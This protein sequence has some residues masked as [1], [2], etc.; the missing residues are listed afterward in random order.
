ML[1]LKTIEPMIR[2][3]LAED[4]GPHMRDITSEATIPADRQTMAVM[5]ARG[6]GVIAG[7]K[8]AEAVFKAVDPSLKVTLYVTD[9][10]KVALYT[11]LF[12][13]EGSALSILKAERVALNFLSHLSGIATLTNRYIVAIGDSKAQIMCT[14]KTIPTLRSL[15]KYAVA[16]GGGKNHR[17]GLYDAILIKDNH[18]SVAKSIKVAI[19]GARK[20][21]GPS[22][23][24]EIEVDTLEQLQEVLDCGGA[25][26]VL[27]DN[28][29]L[30]E[31]KRAVDM[32]G[33]KV[34]LEASGG[35][36]LNTVR[37]IAETGV[38]RISI[39]ALT[40]SAPALDIGLDIDL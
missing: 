25:D 20:A 15:Q 6:E 27:L 1:D 26:I 14:R 5:R 38:D 37:S 29:G 39:G 2:Q 18:I 10:D 17:H 7:V 35:V 8:I 9:G 34:L 24:I 23:K 22:A 36:N 33:G 28:M 11:K 3:A 30:E 13:V 31:L 16:V 21:A 32:A 19:E 40:H 12:L 4:L